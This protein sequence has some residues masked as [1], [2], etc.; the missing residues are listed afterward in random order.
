MEQLGAIYRACETMAATAVPTFKGN[1]LGGQIMLNAQP[2]KAFLTVSEAAQ[3]LGMDDPRVL[4][5]MAHSGQLQMIMRQS[6][7]KAADAIKR[8][9][10][11][12]AAEE[13]KRFADFRESMMRSVD[14][15]YSVIVRLLILLGG[16]YLEMG[17]LR[18]SELTEL[19]KG[20]LHIRTTAPD[21]TRRIKSNSGAPK[22]LIL[23]LPQAAVDLIRTVPQRSGRDHLF[24]MG[25]HGLTENDIQKKKL[26]AIVA[27]NEKAF[28][29][30][31]GQEWEPMR[32]WV[33]HWLRHSFT[34]HLSED[35]EI[36]PRVIEAITNH[37]PGEKI[38][39]EHKTYSHAKFAVAQ[40]RVLTEWAR[41]V[42]NA[43]DRVVEEEKTNVTS[44]FGQ[45]AE[46]A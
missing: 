11:L 38:S 24:G 10:Y 35:L 45:S 19:D 33:L 8:R 32:P 25:P 12:I 4:R 26:D 7:K 34:T 16:R 42:R 5:N 46:T 3:L 21:G 13:L 6:R 41:R 44:L 30:S 23:H 27:A 43:A 20:I 14:F 39:G 40:R 2:T 28:A 17:G 22:D 9:S 37:L 15:E 31:Q 29:K 36:D 1:A 18:W